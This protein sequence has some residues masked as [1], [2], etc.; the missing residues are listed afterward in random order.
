MRLYTYPDN[1]DEKFVEAWNVPV[2]CVAHT[3]L[4]HNAVMHFTARQGYWKSAD[5]WDDSNIWVLVWFVF[6]PKVIDLGKAY[7]MV[8]TWLWA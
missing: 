8:P 2:A 6:P 4:M 3:A 5:H 7:C 1:E